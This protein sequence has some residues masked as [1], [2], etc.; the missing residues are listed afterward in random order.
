MPSA[1][2]DTFYCVINAPVVVVHIPISLGVVKVGQL[3]R[4]SCH[5]ANVSGS[6]DESD[7]RKHV[8]IEHR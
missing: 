6:C 4:R 7:Q 8:A 1:D 5:G 3:S 2:L